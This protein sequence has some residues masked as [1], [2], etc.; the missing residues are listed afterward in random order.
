MISRIRCAMALLACLG[1]SQANAQLLNISTQ[2]L[3]SQN[4]PGVACT[5]IG[6][7]GNTWHGM[8]VLV[9]VSEATSGDS[10]P[11]LV[12]RLLENNETMANDDWA[13]TIWSNGT[14]IQNQPQ[15]YSALLRAPMSP[16]DAALLM[17]VPPGWRVCVSSTET[18]GGDALRRANVQIT[19]VTDA[20]IRVIR[21]APDHSATEKTIPAGT[22]NLM[23]TF[24]RT[25]SM[26]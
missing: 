15:I 14:P 18:S 7:A 23:A 21:S 25:V 8:K 20:A 22:P 1:A 3:Q 26:P 16:T 5:I 10:N 13:G 19:D 4:T 9:V 2:A 24:A 6:T 17:S 11:R 12:A